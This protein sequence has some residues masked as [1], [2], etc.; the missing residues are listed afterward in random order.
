MPQLA[1][2]LALGAAAAWAVGMTVAKPA[3]RAI[4]FVTYTMFRWVLVACLA[5]G[6]GALTGS[7]AFPNWHALSLAILAGVLDCG[8]GG[9]LYLSA[10]K[11]TSAHK[12][13]T[14]SSTAPLWGVLGAVL[15]LREPILWQTFVAA[16]LVILGAVFLAERRRGTDGAESFWGDLLALMTGL[17]WG[18]A[19]TVPA[20]LALDAGMTPATMLTV[21][22][23]SGAVTVVVLSPLLRRR[24]PRQVTQRGLALAVLSGVAGAFLGWLL[25]LYALQW[26]PASVISP[27]RGSTLF[28][29]LF[30]SM[31]FLR[32][33]PRVRTWTGIALVAAGVLLVSFV[34]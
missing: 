2:L 23:L 11:R 26:A 22:A 25:W 9:I 12:A 15:V 5:L 24:T 27:I 1:I 28:F 21:F 18:F 3:V 10:M 19:E 33:R 14:L 16:G 13:T 29:A 7:L 30:Y 31:V 6:F 34:S 17:L 8:F 32:E 4:D 20:K